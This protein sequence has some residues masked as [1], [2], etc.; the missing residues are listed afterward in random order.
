MSRPPWE[1]SITAA[2]YRSGEDMEHL[3]TD[4]MRFMAILGFCLVAIFALVRS[5]PPAPIINN[6]DHS[7]INVDKLTYAGN[8]KS[9]TSNNI[10]FKYG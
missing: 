3:Q 9:L 1:T 2:R 5:I 10:I 6:T 4:V 7:V 8:L